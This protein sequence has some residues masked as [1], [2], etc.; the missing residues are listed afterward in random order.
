MATGSVTGD[1]IFI[2]LQERGGKKS[3]TNAPYKRTEQITAGRKANLLIRSLKY[4]LQEARTFW[5][6]SNSLPSTI[7]F[8]SVNSFALR[9]WFNSFNISAE[10]RRQ[11]VPGFP[12]RV[13][14]FY[15]SL[16]IF[17]CK[18]VEKQETIDIFVGKIGS[19]QTVRSYECNIL[20]KKKKKKAGT[21][22][23][24]QLKYIY[25][26]KKAKTIPKFGRVKNEN[27]IFQH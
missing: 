17:F 12:L 24:K 4:K 7:I 22:R 20:K 6:T 16:F 19:T 13:F 3:D 1:S 11:T 8:R 26:E 14:Y 9:C 10:Q 23:S 5:W 27:K 18:E 15:F 21:S 2:N 25:T